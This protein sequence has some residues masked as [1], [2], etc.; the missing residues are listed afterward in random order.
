MPLSTIYQARIMQTWGEG[1]RSLESVFFFDHTAGSGTALTLAE[2]L[3]DG[4]L[5]LMNDLQTQFVKNKSIEVI[6]L[7]E[8]SDFIS[9]P[10]T[11]EGG[12][13]GDSLPP[14]AAVGYTMKLN[15][16]AVRHGGKRFS[17]VPESAQDDGKV[18][19]PSYQTAMEA[20]RLF[21]S[22]EVVG[23]SDTFLPVVVK[24]VRTAVP[25]TVPTRYTYRLPRAG[26]TLVLGEVVS[27]LTSNSLSHQVSRKA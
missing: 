7:G 6:N 18:T 21:L 3:E 10:L 26:D 1:G 16:R 19:D 20:M 17:G 13:A 24:R 15:T 8:L 5:S 25:D 12:W 9:Y 14:Y 4:C 23:A 22:Q 27:V 2:L 11:G